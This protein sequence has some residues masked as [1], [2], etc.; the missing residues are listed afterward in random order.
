MAMLPKISM[1]APIDMKMAANS[2]TPKAIPAP[3][4][5]S[6]FLYKLANIMD[7]QDESQP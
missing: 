3:D 2:P 7:T 5:D 4:A 6:E 1:A